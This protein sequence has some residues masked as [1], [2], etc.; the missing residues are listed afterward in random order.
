V[1]DT[2]GLAARPPRPGRRKS[3]RRN[4][5]RTKRFFQENPIDKTIKNG[6]MAT[7]ERKMISDG[8]YA[9]LFSEL[10][11]LHKKIAM[12][13][14]ITFL[15]NRMM[16]VSKKSLEEVLTLAKKHDI[17]LEDVLVYWNEKAGNND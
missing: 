11:E 13:T 7:K 17:V 9:T 1:L 12:K 16:A 2:K 10:K 4:T 5:L 6:I 15:R 8:E 14:I 3:L